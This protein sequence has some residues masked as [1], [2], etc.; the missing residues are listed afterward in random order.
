MTVITDYLDYDWG[1]HKYSQ[2]DLEW[3]N[4]YTR[5][6]GYIVSEDYQEDYLKYLKMFTFMA[7]GKEFDLPL[8]M[9]NAN[10]GWSG[11]YVHYNDERTGIQIN[12]NVRECRKASTKGRSSLHQ[13][14]LS[15]LRH[16]A[17]HWFLHVSGKSWK[18]GSKDFE[19]LLH[20]VDSDSTM[21]ISVSESKMMQEA[22]MNG[23]FK[24]TT[25]GYDVKFKTVS[26][27]NGY[28]DE[29]RR[30]SRI[31]LVV[32]GTT[33]A[34]LGAIAKHSRGGFMI[35]SEN[36][37]STSEPEKQEGRRNLLYNW[38]T[39]VMALRT[40]MEMHKQNN[41]LGGH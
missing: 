27:H 1:C 26:S 41:N 37:L 12:L 40:L 31:Y 36:Y 13:M 20:K 18:D 25:V 11:C 4:K 7:L 39:R 10:T 9:T 30:I 22:V 38:G 14:V 32:D 33:G 16:E 6:D 35:I 8:V 23:T 15:I 24:K 19:S 28:S 3:F 17:C 29:D 2:E 34:E 21:V 5:M